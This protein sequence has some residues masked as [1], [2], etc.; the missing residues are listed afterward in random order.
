MSD[1]LVVYYS[2]K[3]ATRETAEKLA[4]ILKCDITEITSP[5]KYGG[6]FGFLAG[7]KGAINE[8]IIKINET[9]KSPDN[10][11]M[12]IICSPVW[13]SNIPPAI[14]TYLIKFKDRFKSHSFVLTS[15]GS[16]HAKPLAKMTEIAGGPAK[17]LHFSNFERK[18]KVWVEKLTS[19]ANEL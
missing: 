16:E 8:N 4:E 2:R 1:K 7:G 13:A 6:P 11:E 19:F 9:D 17:I 14:R 18:T 12:V 3:G 10:Y 15:G 5:K